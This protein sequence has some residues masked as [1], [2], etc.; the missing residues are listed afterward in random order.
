MTNIAVIIAEDFED[1]EYSKPAE[2]FKS[3]GYTLT[4][5]G[6]SREGTV[7]GKHHMVSVKTDKSFSDVES[8][9]FDAL[10][11][12][13]GYSPDRLRIDSSAVSFVERFV[14]SNKPVFAICH[15]PQILIT[16]GVLKGRTVTGWKSI[17]QDIKNAGAKFIDSEVVKDGNLISS[18]SPH[19]IPAFIDA[20]LRMLAEVSSSRT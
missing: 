5:I 3:A 15:A 18:R 16:A 10:F 8:L 9:D 14:K 7:H 13:G 19:D 17:E 6:L 20:C 1:N 12:P 2:A 4:H 11:I